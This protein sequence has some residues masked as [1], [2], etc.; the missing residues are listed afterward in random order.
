MTFSRFKN[1]LNTI[2]QKIYTILALFL[3]AKQHRE[4]SHQFVKFALIG[5]INTL[6]DFGIYATLTRH[7]AFFDYHGPTKYLA[8]A[9]SF[10]CGTTFSFFA[11]RTW[12]FR[13]TNAP[14][15]GEALRFYSTTLS[16]LLINSLILFL[17]IRW[18]GINDLVSKIFSTIFST[19]WNFSLKRLWVFAP[20][21]IGEPVKTDA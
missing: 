11:N 7:T 10:V 4:V 19:I 17:F 20:R 6:I 15:P 21:D 18:I 9:I 12:T 1:L 14:T 8:N 3:P 16:G 2:D 5:A 13:Q